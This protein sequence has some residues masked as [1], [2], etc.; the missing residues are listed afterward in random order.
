MYFHL[1]RFNSNKFIFTFHCFLVVFLKDSSSII[2]S[3]LDNKCC[4]LDEHYSCS[5]RISLFEGKIHRLNLYKVVLC[6]GQFSL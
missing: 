4:T 6:T 3:F 5:Q 2:R 1:L